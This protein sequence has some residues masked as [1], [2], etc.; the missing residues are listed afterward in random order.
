MPLHTIHRLRFAP[1]QSWLQAPKDVQQ[2]FYLA[3]EPVAGGVLRLSIQAQSPVG[4]SLVFSRQARYDDIFP[5]ECYRWW[6]PPREADI[7]PFLDAWT[8][9]D[10]MSIV[11]EDRCCLFDVG[12]RILR[13]QRVEAPTLIYGDPRRMGL[14]S[15]PTFEVEID[16]LVESV[17]FLRGKG[18]PPASTQV[19]VLI[20]GSMP[21][22]AQG[23]DLG[24]LRVL[25]L[26]RADTQARIDLVARCSPILLE[27]TGLRF[28]LLPLLHNLQSIPHKG[29][30]LAQIGFDLDEHV[31]WVGFFDTTGGLLSWKGDP[32]MQA[33][34]AKTSSSRL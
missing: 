27:S 7:K 29:A 13:L 30:E 9:A 23:V 2:P 26:K 6:A 22:R 8:Q 18:K 32:S 34:T 15:D 19:D 4:S 5:Q 3:I 11:T 12:G 21:I 17:G 10:A 14:A 1:A 25:T 16:R 31:C 20:H 24:H 33:M 28:S